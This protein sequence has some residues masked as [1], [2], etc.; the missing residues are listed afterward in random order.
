MSRI[1]RGNAKRKLQK[2]ARKI[3]RLRPKSKKRTSQGLQLTIEQK[4]MRVEQLARRREAKQQRKLLSDQNIERNQISKIQDVLSSVLGAENLSALGKKVGFVKR[5]TA[6]ITA[7][8]FV[9]TISFGFFGNGNMSLLSLTSGLRIFFLIDVSCQAFSKKINSAHSVALLK[10]VLKNLIACQLSSELNFISGA[11]LMFNG[12]YLQDSTQITLNEKLSE[13]FRGP[14]GGASSAGVKLDLTYDITKCRVTDMKVTDATSNDQNQSKEILK[15]VKPKSLVV[16][17]LG[18]FSIGV[19]KAIQEKAAYFISRLSI[20][21]YVYLHKDDV[22][23]LD[24]PAYLERL[25]KSDQ[26]SAN[27]KVYVG[28]TERFETRLVAQK[29]PHHVAQQRVNKFREHRKKEA[30]PEYLAWSNFSI[31]ITNIPETVFS[32]EMIICLYK[33]RW[34]IE[35][36]FKNLK[37]NVE[38]DIIK[39]ENKNRVYCL[40]YGKLISITILFMIQNYAVQVAPVDK[41]V[42]GDKL[43]KYLKIENRLH[44]A[45]RNNELDVLLIFLEHD[46]LLLC[47]QKRKR[48]TTCEVIEEALKREPYCEIHGLASQMHFQGEIGR[49]MPFDVDLGD[50]CEEKLG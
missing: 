4:K 12:I 42:S 45:L 33:I 6:E 17:D 8:S 44:Q 48:K 49:N 40:L 47:K 27:I 15:H 19:L 2:Q 11:L 28:Q 16:R 22:E 23:P 13:D 38:I 36:V 5:S 14:G 29:V 21:T 9:Y 18:Y 50:V 20:S 31:F 24:V 37:S 25:S 30:S 32:G 41:E 39:G 46:V 7:M 43:V 10:H 26:S 1:S 3:Q 35:L 34:Q